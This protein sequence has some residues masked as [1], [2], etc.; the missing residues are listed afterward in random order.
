MFLR[1][2]LLTLCFGDSGLVHVLHVD[3]EVGQS[4]DDDVRDALR[5][6][7]ASCVEVGGSGAARGGG[8]GGWHVEGWWCGVAV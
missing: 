6:G 7:W 4:G 8:S 5:R 2:L 3:R 1:L